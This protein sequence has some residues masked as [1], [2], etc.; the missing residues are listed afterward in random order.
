[1]AQNITIAGA[2]YTA[3]PSIMVPKTGGGAALF[4]DDESLA[5]VAHSGSYNDL[6]D[7]PTTID[8]G[9]F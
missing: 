6:K 5:E 2:S 8:G 7:L 3:V 9:T 4:V 1:M